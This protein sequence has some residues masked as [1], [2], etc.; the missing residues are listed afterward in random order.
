MISV[1]IPSFNRPKA[2]VE[3]LR[4][5]DLQEATLSYEVIV[6]DD[7]SQFPL[8]D[9]INTLEFSFP[10]RILRQE[11]QGPGAARNYGVY[12][13]K[14]D[15]ILFTDDDCRPGKHWV[16]SIAEA[17][18]PQVMVGGIT[19][20]ALFSNPYSMASQCLIDALYTYFEGTRLFFLTSNNMAC[21]KD[22]FLELGGFDASLFETSAGEDR[23]F[24]TRWIFKGWDVKVNKHA[25]IHHYHAQTLTSFYRM[26]AKYGR[27]AVSY[28]NSIKA[29]E[30]QM[31]KDVKKK[32]WATSKWPFQIYVMLFPWTQTIYGKLRFG[33]KLRLSVL[34]MLSQVFNVIGYC[35]K[36]LSLT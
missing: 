12:Q 4:A 18:K 17:V 5:L 13:A 23:E 29:L 21:R 15:I 3:C 30:N 26:H 2:L 31:S 24:T 36:K 10:L 25:H 14:G 7:G 28:W 22:D 11:N 1:V 8:V 9:S 33:S 34:L 20:N 16:Q 32:S 27:A 19:Q 6:I 35:S